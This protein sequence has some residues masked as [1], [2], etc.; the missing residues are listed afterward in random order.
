MAFAWLNIWRPDDVFAVMELIGINIRSWLYS[1]ETALEDM[2]L[3]IDEKAVRDSCNR[4][5]SEEF[6]ACLGIVVCRIGSNTFA[7]LAQVVGHYRGDQTQV[8]DRSRG[9]GP[10][11]GETY[12][13]KALSRVHHVPDAVSGPL[14]EQGI[15]YDHRAAVVHYLLDMG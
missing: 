7:H 10:P 15:Q 9:N 3:G 2:V 1:G 12:E 13:I 11:A 6:D 5:S 8:W 14:G 4:L